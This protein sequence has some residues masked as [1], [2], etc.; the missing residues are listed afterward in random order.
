[1]SIH[2]N[3]KQGQFYSTTE[4]GAKNVLLSEILVKI[5]CN[6]LPKPECNPTDK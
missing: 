6:E 3:V 2:L 5:P 1:M 4:T